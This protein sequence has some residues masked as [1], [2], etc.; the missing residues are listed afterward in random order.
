MIQ[1]SKIPAFALFLAFFACTAGGEEPPAPTARW[2]K[3]NTHSHTV[4]CGHADSSPEEVAR[5]YHGRGYHFLIL[6]EHN[7]FIDP[8]SVALPADKRPD[9]ILIPGEELTGHMHIHT[10]GMNTRRF[11]PAHL[12]EGLTDENG[13]TLRELSSCFLDERGKKD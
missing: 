9:F 4:L 8:D 7:R 10:T 1:L 12:P 6:S 2:Y 11:V 3:G 13:D 5:W